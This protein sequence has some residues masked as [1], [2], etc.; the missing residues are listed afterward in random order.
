M[1]ADL[2]FFNNKGTILRKKKVS[3]W[4]AYNEPQE[5]L[6]ISLPD[7]NSDLF[8]EVTINIKDLKKELNKKKASKAFFWR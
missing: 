6:C 2:K 1:K 5:V 3:Y 7:S 8:Q 4:Y